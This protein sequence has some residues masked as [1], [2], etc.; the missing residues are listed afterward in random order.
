MKKIMIATALL[1]SIA[2]AQGFDWFK[3][4]DTDSDGQISLAEWI[5]NTKSNAKK[6][7]QTYDEAKSTEIFRARDLNGDGFISRE[8]FDATRKQETLG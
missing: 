6:K 7:R 4:L 3:Q 2:A 5:A 8:E 1:A